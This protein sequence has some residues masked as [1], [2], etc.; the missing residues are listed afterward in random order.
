VR[1]DSDFWALGREILFERNLFYQIMEFMD[2]GKYQMNIVL[3]YF[4]IACCDNF[5]LK[6]KSPSNGHQDFVENRCRSPPVDPAFP[7]QLL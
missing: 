5:I 7:N 4:S 3:I 1:T 2:D 6:A